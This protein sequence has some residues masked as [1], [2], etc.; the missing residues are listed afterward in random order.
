MGFLGTF[1]T[2]LGFG[3]A[4]YYFFYFLS[5]GYGSGRHDDYHGGD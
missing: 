1:L 2:A 4:V 5:G 3:L